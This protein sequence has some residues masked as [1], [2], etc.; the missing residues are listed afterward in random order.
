MSF[1]ICSQIRWEAKGSPRVQHGQ[2][3]LAPEPSPTGGEQPT[4][5]LWLSAG[6]RPRRLRAASTVLL[7]CWHLWE[8]FK[9]QAEP[10]R[11]ELWGGAPQGERGSGAHALAGGGSLTSHSLGD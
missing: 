10:P 5:A 1:G 8:K 7:S 11:N 2:D 9:F 4:R 6:S 3:G